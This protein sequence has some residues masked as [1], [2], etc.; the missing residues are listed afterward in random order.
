MK[1]NTTHEKEGDLKAYPD[2]LLVL[3]PVYQYASLQGQ[4]QHALVGFFRPVAL[5]EFASQV[6]Y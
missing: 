4:I 6:E 1:D 3:H 2:K 5:F